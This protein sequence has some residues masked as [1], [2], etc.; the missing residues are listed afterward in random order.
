M[1]ERRPRHMFA[2]PFRLFRR[3]GTLPSARSAPANRSP[4]NA[5]DGVP[6]GYLYTFPINS[7]GGLRMF[8]V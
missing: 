2:I 1:P 4:R 7:S 6:Y 5:G 3:D 8:P